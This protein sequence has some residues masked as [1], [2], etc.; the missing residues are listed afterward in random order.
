MIFAAVRGR[1]DVFSTTV[2]RFV[3][4]KIADFLVLA[5]LWWQ[6]LANGH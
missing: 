2:G 6:L 4:Q 3:P 5:K 1:Y